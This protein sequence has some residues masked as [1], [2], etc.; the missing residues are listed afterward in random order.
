MLALYPKK[1]L[2]PTKARGMG[3]RERGFATNLGEAFGKKRGQWMFVESLP[4]FSC[5]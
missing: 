4:A 3:G 2:S 1:S 5:R